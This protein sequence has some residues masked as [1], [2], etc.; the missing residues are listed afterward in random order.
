MYIMALN[1]DKIENIE[2][3]GNTNIQGHYFAKN[4]KW[5]SF[6]NHYFFSKLLTV[7]KNGV[8]VLFFINNIAY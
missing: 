8:K 5:I 7:G 3:Q 1:R 2:F 4:K 6:E